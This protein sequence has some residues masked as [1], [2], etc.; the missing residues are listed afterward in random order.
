M[1]TILD[2]TTRRVDTTSLVFPPKK[3]YLNRIQYD[4]AKQYNKTQ[5][6]IVWYK[7]DELTQ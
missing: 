6:N 2:S 1:Y 5:Y 7:G 4:M 3:Y